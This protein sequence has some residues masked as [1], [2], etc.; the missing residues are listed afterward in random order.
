MEQAMDKS[1]L[2]TL[3]SALVGKNAKW[4]RDEIV[5]LCELYPDGYQTVIA[6]IAKSSGRTTAL[7]DAL[8]LECWQGAAVAIEETF[9]LE[10]D[11]YQEGYYYDY[12]FHDSCGTSKPDAFTEAIDGLKQAT[13]QIDGA[14]ENLRRQIVAKAVKMY[15][16]ANAEVSLG[17]FWDSGLDDELW[18]FI[19]HLCLDDSDLRVLCDLLE[20]QSDSWSTEKR[21]EVLWELGDDAAFENLRLANLSSCA[22]YLD[23][24]EFYKRDQKHDLAL[25]YAEQGLRQGEGRIDSLAK[26]LIDHYASKGLSDRL[27]QTVTL[28]M[29]CEQ[30]EYQ[31]AT[32]AFDYFR[33]HSN[34]ELA[35]KYLLVSITHISRSDVS[36][37]YKQVEGF[38]TKDDFAQIETLLLDTIKAVDHEIY[39]DVLIQRG[40]LREAMDAMR[41]SAR[42]TPH[43]Y[44]RVDHHRA[45]EQLAQHF[46]EEIIEYYFGFATSLI[47]LGAGRN[48]KNYKAAVDYLSLARHVYLDVLQDNAR[49]RRKLTE[50][51]GLYQSRRAFLEESLILD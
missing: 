48:R 43:R 49:W 47:G 23:L 16:T 37:L 9:D 11:F 12:G 6:D 32:A 14:S 29:E 45:A 44:S 13:D 22:D 10:E 42:P 39:L 24:V 38:L 4:L 36:G 21:L 35:K 3:S 25:E 17:A 51:R 18:D 33:E 30:Y 50:I 19:E 40:E 26:F 41:K 28:C 34:Y 1:R 7:A 27:E 15:G 8:L 5:R 46:P 2:E 31:S 20:Q